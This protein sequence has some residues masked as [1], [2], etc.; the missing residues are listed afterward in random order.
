MG[1]SC[2]SHLAPIIIQSICPEYS[3]CWGNENHPIVRYPWCKTFR[4]RFFTLTLPP[5]KRRSTSDNERSQLIREDH[6]ENKSEGRISLQEEE[7]SSITVH[8]SSVFSSVDHVVTSS[9]PNA[10]VQRFPLSTP[11]IEEKGGRDSSSS[12]SRSPTASI[13]QTMISEKERI[14]RLQRQ[15]KEYLLIQR[16]TEKRKN[17]C[18]YLSGRSASGPRWMML[19]VAPSWML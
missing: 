3:S 16:R 1:E 18:N 8:Y 7:R 12:P 5:P 2:L 19:I 14:C 4:S 9:P 11:N 15:S 13:K 17:S 6:L 10:L